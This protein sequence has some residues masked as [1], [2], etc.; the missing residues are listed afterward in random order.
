[1]IGMLRRNQCYQFKYS[2]G[3]STELLLDVRIH[4][5]YNII[6]ITTCKALIIQVL[7]INEVRILLKKYFDFY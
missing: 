5:L 6:H 4:E 2:V 3:K 7:N 1:M